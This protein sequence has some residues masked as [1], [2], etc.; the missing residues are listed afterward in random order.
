MRRVHRLVVWSVVIA[1]TITGSGLVPASAEEDPRIRAY[2]EQLD[3]MQKEMDDM[4][5]RL[6]ALEAEHRTSKGAAAAPVVAPAPAPSAPAPQQAAA[7]PPP[8]PAVAEQDRKI[9]VLATEVERLKSAL[10][11]PANKEMKSAYGLG[12]AAS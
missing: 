12:P 7:A 10:V 2:Q 9:G 11:L 5:A 3:R 8:A 1:I 6:R 4:R